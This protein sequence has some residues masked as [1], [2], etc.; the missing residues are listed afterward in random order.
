M[1]TACLGQIEETKV[2]TALCRSRSV[3]VYVEEE[4]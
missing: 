3:V 2:L 1:T 4:V